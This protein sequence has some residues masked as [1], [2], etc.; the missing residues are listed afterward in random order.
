[1]HGWETYF[2]FAV[3]AV[4]FWGL[5]RDHAPDILLIGGVVAFMLVGIIKP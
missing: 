3:L 2:A 4:V 1:M 5:V